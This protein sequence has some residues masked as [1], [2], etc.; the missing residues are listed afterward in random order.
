[1]I[2]TIV[3]VGFSQSLFAAILVSAKKDAQM[4]DKILSAW[5]FLLSFEF[6]TCAI[7][8]LI[9]KIPLL[10]SS[11]L[12]F[13]PAFFLYIKSLTDS[14]FK[15]RK[16]QLLH[17]LPFLTFEIGAYMLKQKYNLHNFFEFD[18]AQ[19]FRLAF[20]IASVIS[21]IIYNYLSS[22]MVFKLRRKLENEFSTISKDKSLKWL[23][24]I[25]VFYNI[26]CAFS[27][28][29]AVFAISLPHTG[30]TQYIY[31]YSALLVLIYI[32]GF[33]GLRQKKIFVATEEPQSTKSKYQNSALSQERKDKIS[34]KIINYIETTQAYL[35]PEL[36]MNLLSE[37]IDIP[38]HQITEVLSTELEK[39][40]FN[41]IN[42]YRVNAVKEL[43]KDKDTNYSIEGIGY[44]CG[45]SSK[46]S[47][48]TVFKKFTGMTPSEYK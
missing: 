35:N 26:F 36:N 13:N 4:Q 5:L 32:L 47:F 37:K 20:S 6:L 43:L 28:V 12:L 9:W 23:V 17:L 21:W 10:S 15:L 44:D 11:F 38:K 25:I 1:M 29:V 45:F 46:S 40:F 22:I 42:E 16:I 33:Y 2:S 24:F 7:D 41:L 39:N 48:F 34:K 8:I 31:N 14:K 27:L 18:S 19:W 3:W 30:I